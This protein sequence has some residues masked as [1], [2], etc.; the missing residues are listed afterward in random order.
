MLYNEFQHKLRHIHTQ[1][2]NN[3]KINC[4]LLNLLNLQIPSFYIY[5][6]YIKPVEPS[7][8]LK[9]TLLMAK[10]MPLLNEKTKAERVISPILLE[11]VKNYVD[12]ISFFFR[13]KY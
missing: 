2:L 11:V 12:K 7:E 10:L 9:E 8:W 5:H 4:N 6:F 1:N 3:L 13:R